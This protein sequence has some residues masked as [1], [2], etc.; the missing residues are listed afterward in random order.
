MIYEKLHDNPLKSRDDLA[1]A[2][3][4]L[5]DPLFAHLSPS[6]AQ[7]QLKSTGAHYQESSIGLEGFSRSLYG[8]VPYIL[9]GFNL[10]GKYKD[11]IF[12]RKAFGNIRNSFLLC[13]VKHIPAF[14]IETVS[15]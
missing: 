3:E 8:T 11:I 10:S 12:F 4:D 5:I 15:A 13:R 2:L 1:R 6:R 14:S 7:V 9:G